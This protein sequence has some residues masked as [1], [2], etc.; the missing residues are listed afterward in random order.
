MHSFLSFMSVLVLVLQV[1]NERFI[2]IERCY[3]AHRDGA[4]TFLPVQAGSSKFEGI[5]MVVGMA[6]AAMVVTV[7]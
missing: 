4:K 1:K 5:V 2:G 7:W 6:A 3:S